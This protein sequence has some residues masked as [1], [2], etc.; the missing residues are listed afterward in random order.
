MKIL[1]VGDSW[2]SAV[3]GDTGMDRGWPEV[4]GIPEHCRQGISG[5]TAYEWAQ[6]KDERLSRAMEANADIIF[7]SLMGNDARHAYED[8]KVTSDEVSRALTSMRDVVKMLSGRSRVI[9]FLYADPF[10]GKDLI[11]KY[12]L[13]MLNA[14]I[15]AATFLR[16]ECIDLGDVLGPEHFDGK[17]IHPTRVGHEVMAEYLKGIVE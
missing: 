8:G 2:A 17:D 7:L 1:A 15:R 9:A 13:P 16:A 3:E 10:A 11:Y 5:S 14:G 12:G 6:N 4:M